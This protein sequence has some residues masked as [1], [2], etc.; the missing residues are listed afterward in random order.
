MGVIGWPTLMTATSLAY[1]SN[2]RLQVQYASKQLD[3]M[4][5]GD[6]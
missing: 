1:Q 5:R 4:S 3:Q 6:Y 2:N